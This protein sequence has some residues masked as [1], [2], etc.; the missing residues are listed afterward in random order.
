MP[1]R[2]CEF[3]AA[4]GIDPKSFDALMGRGAARESLKEFAAAAEDYLEAVRL[5]PKSPEANLRL[6]L[7]LLTMKRT[8]LGRRYLERIVELDPTGEAGAKARQLLEATPAS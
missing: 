8:A 1:R 6:G 4:I 2:K 5:Q 7:V 3:T